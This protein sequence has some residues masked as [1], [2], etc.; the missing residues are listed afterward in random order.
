MQ[1]QPCFSAV[2]EVIEKAN[3]KFGEQYHLNKDKA[4]R[5][6]TICEIIDQMIPEFDCEAYDVDVDD[7]TRR[8][9]IGVECFDLILH[10]GTSNKFFELINLVDGFRFS[11][12]EEDVLRTEFYLNTMWERE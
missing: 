7:I 1:Y 12:K 5:L 3:L 11:K 10:Q 2:D 4:D 8:L 9:T 6:E